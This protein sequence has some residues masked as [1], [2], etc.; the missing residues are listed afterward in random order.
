MT[1]TRLMHCAFSLISLL[2]L[3]T[4]VSQQQLEFLPPAQ[5]DEGG[6]IILQD[7]EHVSDI[8]HGQPGALLLLVVYSDTCRTDLVNMLQE[9]VQWMQE[10]RAVLEE[11]A[12]ALW[13]ST[14]VVLPKLAKLDASAVD[15]S[16]MQTLHIQAH[17]SLHMFR[18]DKL[19]T[20]VMD[21]MGL[22][23]GPSDIL[24]TL[25]H[26]WIRVAMGPILN[27][28][29]LQHLQ[30]LLNKYGP[31]IFHHVPTPI[32]PDYTLQEQKTIRWL[33]KNTE[34]QDPYWVYISCRSSDLTDL[35]EMTRT[36][37]NVALFHLSHDDDSCNALF[38]EGITA[39]AVHPTSFKMQ[40][41]HEVSDR[42]HLV[43]QASPSVLFYDR[44]STG[45]ILFDRHHT[46]HVVLF[47]RLDQDEPSR[48]AIVVLRRAC[49]RVHSQNIMCMVVPE[50]ETR[51]LSYFDIDIWQPLDDAVM[52]E[53]EAE[54]S[55]PQPLLPALLITD[56]RTKTFLRYYLNAS[57]I[58]RDV[59]SISTFIQDF[60][61]NKLTPEIKSSSK[62]V[63]TTK[64]GIEIINGNAFDSVVL[65]R[66]DKHTLLYLYAPTCGHCK[67]FSTIWKDFAKLVTAAEWNS[68]L[69][70][71][72]M[73]VTENQ[74][75]SL[76][77]AFLP[78]LYYFASGSQVAIPFNVT[79]KFGDTVGRL[80]D[81]LEIVDWMLTVGDFD[82]GQLIRSLQALVDSSET[83]SRKRT[84]KGKR[85]EG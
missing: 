62:P 36:L 42:W 72:Q 63:R 83:T 51:I 70:L 71:V 31:L 74:V 49:Q 69:D 35:S 58:A 80:N 75:P 54:N 46:R 32:N 52:E 41:N 56:Q 79:D 19:E 53:T 14:A 25:I 38:Q 68:F 26:T 34:T 5:V 61:D 18:Q 8:L 50:T 85:S 37:R 84:K 43:S 67:R 40:S 24:D 65:D 64:L 23:E 4:A 59:N 60:M 78:A 20:V 73:D 44:V 82:Q 29:N 11:L 81:P 55:K 48:D 47:V 7:V 1:T 30:T 27:V 28:N 45:P 22:A 39:F 57:A 16:W 2:L 13:P 17:P 76:D 6:L 66:I 15:P 33:M 77:P 3:Q 10:E 12:K 21:Y 9:V